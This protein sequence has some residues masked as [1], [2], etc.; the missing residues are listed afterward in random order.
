MA[1][2]QS[3]MYSRNIYSSAMTPYLATSSASDVSGQSMWTS[4]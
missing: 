1:A 2:S 3:Q 4:Q